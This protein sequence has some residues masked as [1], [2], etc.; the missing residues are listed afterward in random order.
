MSSHDEFNQILFFNVDGEDL[1]DFV[2]ANH[3]I[4]EHIADRNKN[5][6]VGDSL[7]VNE[8]SS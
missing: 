7:A 3:A 6:L 5:Q 4:S 2:D 8:G 1:A